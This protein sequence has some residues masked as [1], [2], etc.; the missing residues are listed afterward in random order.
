MF[1]LHSMT[2]FMQLLYQSN[3]HSFNKYLLTAYYVPGSFGCWEGSC[4]K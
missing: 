3:I 2:T 1:K 4:E